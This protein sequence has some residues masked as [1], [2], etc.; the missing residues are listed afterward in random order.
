MVALVFYLN[1]FRNNSTALQSLSSGVDPDRIPFMSAQRDEH[2]ALKLRPPDPEYKEFMLPRLPKP[3]YVRARDRLA[4]ISYFA[5]W[6]DAKN[7]WRYGFE[8]QLRA[9][10]DLLAEWPCCALLSR[11]PSIYHSDFTEEVLPPALE[12]ELE[13]TA[14]GIDQFKRRAARDDTTLIILAATGDMGTLGYPQ[15]DRLSA[16]AEARGI[17]IIS[18]YD[19]IV[20]QGYDEADGRWRNDDHWNAVGH[21]WVAEAVLEW[22]KDNQEVCD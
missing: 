4:R 15:F 16:I 12:D 13:Y 5:K 9:W 20:S 19:Y 18:H 22:L 8:P 17:P 10:A 14:F 6:I 21:Q 3:W 7:F 2:G 1:D 11:G